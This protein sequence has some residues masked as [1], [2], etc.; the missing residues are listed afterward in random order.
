MKLLERIILLKFIP[1]PPLNAE[2]S[3]DNN[4]P[5]IN[6][7]VSTSFAKLP[8]IT[9]AD[10]NKNAEF[11]WNAGD[12]SPI[13]F[14]NNDFEFDSYNISEVIMFLQRLSRNPNASGTNM[15]F[16][17]HITNALMQ[18]MHVKCI[19]EF[20]IFS[21]GFLL[22]IASYKGIIQCFIVFWG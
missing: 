17:K 19:D 20:C 8:K 11:F 16:T 21:H 9:E 12:N 1:S 3:K 6:D 10:S 4:P 14:D 18:V 5:T 13:T 2:I 7:K 15:D 22:H